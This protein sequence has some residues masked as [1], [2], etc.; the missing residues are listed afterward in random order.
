LPSPSLGA[1]CGA[2]APRALLTLAACLLAPLAQ[3]AISVE[4]LLDEP[5]WQQAQVIDDFVVTQPFT[6]ARPDFP[7]EARILG[8]PAGIAVAFLVTQPPGVARQRAQTPRDADIPGD[9]VTVYVDFNADGVTAYAFTVGLSGAVQDATLTDENKY[10]TDWDGDWQHAVQ[11]QD[12]RWTVEILILW[13]TASMHGSATA[14]RTLAVLFERNLGFNGQHSSSAAESFARR[15]FVSHFPRLQLAQYVQSEFHVFP[16][17]SV[18]DNLLDSRAD[19][20]TGLDLFWKPSGDFQLAAALNPDFGQ[21]ESD[22]LVV[23]FDAIETFF[24]DKR[25]FFTENQGFFDLPTPN[26]GQLIYSRRI[27]AASDAGAGTANIDAALK[28]NWLGARAQLWRFQRARV[29]L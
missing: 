2:H 10:S 23:N 25:P 14:Q 21:I 1:R 20:K 26:G 18:L 3:A 19:F 12:A 17:V 24:S 13:S 16:Y 6:L 11:E 8:T 22:N 9:S 28:F 15:P 5:E 29:R 27:G 4:G 7:T